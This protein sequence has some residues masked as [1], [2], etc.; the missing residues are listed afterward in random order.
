MRPNRGM[1]ADNGKENRLKKGNYK[2][3]DT[4]VI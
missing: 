3:T 4:G 1:F 2:A